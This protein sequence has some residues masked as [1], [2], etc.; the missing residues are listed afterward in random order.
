MAGSEPDHRCLIST[1]FDKI[2]R[3]RLDGF[4][5]NFVTIVGFLHEFPSLLWCV[6]GLLVEDNFQI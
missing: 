2:D 3:R 4:A 5:P 6:A 1:N